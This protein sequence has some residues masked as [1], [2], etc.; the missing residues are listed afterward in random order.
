[1][2]KEKRML[3]NYEIAWAVSPLLLQARYPAK[4]QK[5]KLCTASLSLKKI[6]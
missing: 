3:G 1:M 6:K 2:S 5:T 4:R